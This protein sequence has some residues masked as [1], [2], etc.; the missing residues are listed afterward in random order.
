MLPISRILVP[1]DFSERC[2]GIMPFVKN[3]ADKY[4]AEV[5]LLHVV[6]VAYSVPGA[7]ISGHAVV[8]VPQ[9]VF[10]EKGR[11]R[12]TFAVAELQGVSVHRVLDKGDPEIQIS[13]EA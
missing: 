5:T 6:N 4:K 9:W 7:G 11:Q 1:V 3:I 13:V 12:E 8:P 2:L 10:E